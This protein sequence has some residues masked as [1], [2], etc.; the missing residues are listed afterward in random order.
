MFT[1][2][3]L[4]KTKLWNHLLCPLVDE[5]IKKTCYIDT[6]EYYSVIKKNENMLFSGKWTELE[7][8]KLSKISLSQK[9]KYTM[10]SLIYRI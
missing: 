3:L 10:F 9:N 7:I 1:A 4:I 8:I 6:M 2:A 5:Q